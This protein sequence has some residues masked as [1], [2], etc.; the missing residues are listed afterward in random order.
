[1]NIADVDFYQKSNI[2]ERRALYLKICC[3]KEMTVN[4]QSVLVMFF[5]QFRKLSS[6]SAHSENHRSGSPIMLHR[7]PE[8][9]N[10]TIL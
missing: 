1:M 5:D 9:H 3:T 8:S 7:S 10:D 6:T 4:Y 2:L